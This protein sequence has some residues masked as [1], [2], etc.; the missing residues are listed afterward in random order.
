MKK[1]FSSIAMV[2]VALASVFGL[3]S[4]DKEDIPVDPVPE[5][6]P[7]VLPVDSLGCILEYEYSAEALELFDIKYEVTDFNGN[8]E[9]FEVTKP[10]K[11]VK[12]YKAKKITDE[13]NVRL[14][15]AAKDVN[16]VGKEDKFSFKAYSKVIYAVFAGGK[17]LEVPNYAQTNVFIN[18]MV[19]GPVSQS[20]IKATQEYFVGTFDV[21]MFLPEE[22]KNGISTDRIFGY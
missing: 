1:Y 2:A 9:T 11:D 3:T 20:D 6:A 19:W 10:G 12:T 14:I 4:C 22:F 16:A 17:T 15:V 18:N 8:T 21:K 5:P 13:G 7:Q